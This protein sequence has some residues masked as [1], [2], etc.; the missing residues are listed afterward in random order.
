MYAQDLFDRVLGAHSG[1][2]SAVRHRWGSLNPSNDNVN[3]FKP[4]VQFIGPFAL[5]GGEA[6]TH[7]LRLPQYVGSVR[8]M[9]VAGGD[10]AYGNAEKT[11]AVKSDLMTLSTLPRVLGPDEEVWLPVNVFAQNNVRNVKVSIQTKG[12][13][14]PTDGTTKSISFDKSGDDILFFK[15]QSGRKPGGTSG[16]KGPGTVSRSPKPSTS[17]YAIPTHPP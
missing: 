2:M 17:R 14:K 5:K 11:V 3:R 9:V 4:I 12:L 13:L 16:D 15:L 6:K 7:T 8:V 10:G 1:T